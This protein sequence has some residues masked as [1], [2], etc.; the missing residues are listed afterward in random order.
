MLGLAPLVVVTV[1]DAHFGGP[2]LLVMASGIL[3]LT[4]AITI[5]YLLG[6]LTRTPL[7][8]PVAFLLFLAAAAVG[9]GDRSSSFAA[10][11]PVLRV[12]PPL[13]QVENTPLVLFRC[14]FFLLATAV[15]AVMSARV[16]SNR[17]PRTMSNTA[18]NIAVAAVPAALAL[19]G[20][21]NTPPLFAL[22]ADPPRH[23]TE[24]GGIEYCVHEGHRTELP[25]LVD[26][27][28]PVFASYGEQ[29][30]I[31]RVYDRALL[32]QSGTSAIAREPQGT[33]VVVLAPRGALTSEESRQGEARFLADTLS[34]GPVCIDRY[35][36][37]EFV[38][39][40]D[41]PWSRANDLSKWLV[42]FRGGLD[43]ENAFNGMSGERMRA[44]I[45]EKS[46]AILSCSLQEADLPK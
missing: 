31:H 25:F 27:L 3:G 29:N 1:L 11:L 18:T 40:T 15:A 12:D 44:W 6:V 23:C 42:P 30:R 22:P 9:F 41:H 43:P 39:G 34:G 20:T 45:A 5:G 33:H 2:D 36:R 26:A 24:R 28:D 38:D 32:Y 10:V 19:V 37:S 16:L 7:I 14:G 21:A 4:A 13:G 17:A 46:D 35:H 8:A